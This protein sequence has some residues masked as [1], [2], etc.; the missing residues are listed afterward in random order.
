MRL[1]YSPT[2]TRAEVEI[3]LVDERIDSL[4]RLT[5]ISIAFE[6]M[7]VFYV[8]NSDVA[9]HYALVERTVD[10]PF[11]KDYDSIP[12]NS[13][14]DWINEFDLTNWGLIGAYAGGE[15]AGT[16]LIAHDTDGVTMLEGRKDLAV[17]WDLRVDPKK[18]RI[19]IGSALFLAAEE[20]AAAKGC[21]QLKIETQNVNVPA[22]RFYR[23]QRCR[24]GGI[25]RSAYPAFPDEI[26]LLWY[27]DL[28][29]LR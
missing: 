18:R 23:M 29:R 16:A 2:S 14:R 26:Q 22:C 1:A 15:R 7:R 6:V 20:W 19:G 13:P 9:G 3:T 28:H 21:I 11:I 5:D 4:E 17:L 8:E 24:L 27:K 25:A 12:G 10:K